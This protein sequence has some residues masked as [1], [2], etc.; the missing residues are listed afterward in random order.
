MIYLYVNFSTRI[1]EGQASSLLDLVLITN[2]ENFIS[3]ITSLPPLGKCDHITSTV[4]VSFNFQ[5]Y[6]M[7][8]INGCRNKRHNYG[9]GDNYHAVYDF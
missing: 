4:H 9:H 3:E 2:D 8:K 6:L 7:I 1:R 5:C